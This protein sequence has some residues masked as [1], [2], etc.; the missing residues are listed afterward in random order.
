MSFVLVE[1]VVQRVVQKGMEDVR[2]NIDVLD[3][4]FCQYLEPELEADYG[5]KYVDQIKS[6]FAN[7]KIPVV[8]AWSMN[9]QRIPCYSIHLATELEDESK[10][11]AGDYYGDGLEGTIGVG[12]FSVMV[13]I[14]C[15]ANKS[16]DQVIWLY[17]IL[18]Y[19][20][21]KNKLVAERMGLQLHTFNASDYSKQHQYM[22]ENIFTRWVRFRCTTENTWSA[23]EFVEVDELD[24]DLQASRV[25]SDGHEED[26]N[27]DEE[28]LSLI[29]I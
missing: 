26:C 12:V 10:A 6:W 1:N 27:G 8:Q 9:P 21:F 11:A 22:T 19:I 24:M 7:T 18:A 3:E 16:G 4:V 5:Q 14:G 17:Y 20:L 25:N 23:E 28:D 2:N 29:H 15:H 13:D